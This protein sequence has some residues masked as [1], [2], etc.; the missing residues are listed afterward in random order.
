MI[1]PIPN[2]ILFGSYPQKRGGLEK[3]P[4]QWLI[5]EHGE[6][7]AL[8][9]SK[10]LLD[11]KPYH[12]QP[13]KITWEKCGLRHWL[14]HDFFS[15]AFTEEEQKRIIPSEIKNQKNST[16]DSV[17]L[18]NADQAEYYFSFETRRAKVTYFAQERG[19]WSMEGYGVW[20]LRYSGFDDMGEEGELDGISCVNFDGYI[21]V[22]ASQV[23]DSECSVRPAIWLAL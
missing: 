21:E 3:E 16:I 12:P 9:V 11:C 5:L 4:I 2:T 6:G 7:K 18:L 1:Y 22:N 20:W 8:C 10:F 19:A 14:N 23:T 15:Q 13:E 17:F